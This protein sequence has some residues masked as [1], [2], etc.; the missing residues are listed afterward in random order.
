MGLYACNVRRL[1]S[2][3]RKPA[4]FLAL[5]VAYWGLSCCCCL[6][7]FA[8]VVCGFLLGCWFFFPLDACDKKK[9][10]HNFLRP[11]WVFYFVLQILVQLLKN[12]VAVALARSNS[13]G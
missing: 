1:R 8:P 3:K 11:L 2:E 5:A 12:S 9:K 4:N 10:G 13:F 6:V 7:C